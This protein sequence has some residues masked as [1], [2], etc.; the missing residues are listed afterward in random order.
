M[1]VLASAVVALVVAL[2]PG[3]GGPGPDV[4]A[5]PPIDPLT[6][7]PGHDE[8]LE[9]RAA[10]GYSHVLYAKSPGGVQATARRVEAFRP[11]VER[12]AEQGD[13]DADVLEAIVF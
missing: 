9:E 10:A 11:A 3:C 2:G 6:Y 4:P 8:D 5:E 13:V 7:R 12:A 1:K